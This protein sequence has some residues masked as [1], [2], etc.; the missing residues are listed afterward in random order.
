[1]VQSLHEAGSEEVHWR[2]KMQTTAFTKWNELVCKSSSTI[3]TKSSLSGES[4]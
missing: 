4:A 3:V 1:M 2:Q